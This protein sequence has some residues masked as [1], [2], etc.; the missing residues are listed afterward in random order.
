VNNAIANAVN[1]AKRATEV[2]PTNVDNWANFALVLQSITSFTR[3]ADEQA[4]ALYQEALKRE[5]T[6]PVYYSEMGKIYILR[7]DAYRQLLQASD[8]KVRLDTEQKIKVELD[9]AVE[10]LNQSILMKP[11][12]AAAH[13]NLGLVYERQGKLADAIVKLEQVL[14]TDTQNVGVGFQLAILYYRNNEKEKSLSILEQIVAVQPE[15]S[16]ARWYLSAL[17]EEKAEYDKAIAQVSKVVELNP[18]DPS[19]KSRL[20]YLIQLRDKK[21]APAPV[22]MLEPL[23]QDIQGPSEQNEVRR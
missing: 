4:I 18:D 2:A 15:Y 16:D 20:D 22:P 6:N 21:S 3:G 11:D 7:A 14:Q 10:V 12:F 8:E 9:K 17:Y 1:S 19:V 5:P 13:Y 23:S